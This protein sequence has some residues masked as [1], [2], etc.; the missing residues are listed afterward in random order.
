MTPSHAL[1][2]SLS[3]PHTHTPLRAL[4]QNKTTPGTYHK[5]FLMFPKKFWDDAMW[6]T[7]ASDEV[8]M[9]RDLAP[10]L[11]RGA[12]AAATPSASVSGATRV[13]G[14][15]RRWGERERRL[16]L[17]RPKLAAAARKTHEHARA[18]LLPQ[19]RLPFHLFF[20]NPPLA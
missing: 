11:W 18:A 17:S 20:V 16:S 3:P 9:R 15:S 19:P 12:C 7:Q 4:V 1:S 14:W 13:D 5:M 8:E 10:R 6:I 2:L